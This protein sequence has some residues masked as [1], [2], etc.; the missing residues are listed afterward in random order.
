MNVKSGYAAMFTLIYKL[1]SRQY[2]KHLI[3]TDSYGIFVIWVN[4]TF[5]FIVCTSSWWRY[6]TF[7]VVQPMKRLEELKIIDF[8]CIDCPFHCHVTM[9][10]FIGYLRK[11]YKLSSWELVMIDDVVMCWQSILRL[12]ELQ[13][14][15]P[16]LQT[17]PVKVLCTISKN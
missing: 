15:D 8:D 16:S 11:Y 14:A 1:K 4:H 2:Y 10:G 6:T 7:Y 3:N 9:S 17:V 13:C 12:Y 5:I